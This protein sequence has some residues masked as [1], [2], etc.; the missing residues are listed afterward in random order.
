MFF[1]FSGGFLVNEFVFRDD[2]LIGIFIVKIF[3]G[4]AAGETIAQRFNDAVAF[5]DGFDFDPVD[6]VQMND[7]TTGIAGEDFFNHACGEFLSF[8]VKN[9]TGNG[10]HIFDKFF[11]EHAIHHVLT[12]FFAQVV[13]GLTQGDNGIF[14]GY[15][16]VF[17]GVRVRTAQDNLRNQMFADRLQVFGGKFRTFRNDHVTRFRIG[18]RRFEN[19]SEQ[20]I[21]HRGDRFFG[22]SRESTAFAN[23]ID[24][25]N[26][27]IF[28]PHDNIR[29]RDDGS[30]NRSPPY[31]EPYRPNL[32][33]RR[34]T[35]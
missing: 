6:F 29:R 2:K 14:T 15:V 11:A 16:F 25:N 9:F 19:T 34:A 13:F 24:G 20:F 30:G 27:A 1:N 17:F 28:F 26:V 23:E 8:L 18:D 32:Y 22:R 10:F 33:A 4:D 31:E 21:L 7:N 12:Q 35:M 5:N 3:R